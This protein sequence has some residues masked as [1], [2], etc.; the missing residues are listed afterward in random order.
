MT[1]REIPI[2]VVDAEP[3]RYH[4]SPS[5]LVECV[6]KGIYVRAWWP[7]DTQIAA[8]DIS[9]LNTVSLIAWLR[10]RGGENVWAERTVAM[11]VGHPYAEVVAA[12]AA[13]DLPSSG[14]PVQVKRGDRYDP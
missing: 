13:L 5:R 2:T 7:D 3:I 10:S 8:V 11:L 12:F 6:D 14:G 9:Q 1:D 4:V